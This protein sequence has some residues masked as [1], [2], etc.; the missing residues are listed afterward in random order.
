[1]IKKIDNVLSNNLIKNIIEYFKIVL[2]RQEWKSSLGWDQSLAPFSANILVHEITCNML[3]KQIKENVEKAIKVDF[4]KENL[5]FMP[6]IYIWNAGSYITWHPDDRYPY[7]GT[8][9]LNEEWDSNDGGL[10]LYKENETNEI[11]GIE[12]KY[13]TMVVNSA[14]ETNKHNYHCV[15]YIVPGSLKKR[16]TIQ[17]RTTPKEKKSFLYQ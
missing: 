1:M 7:S 13:N 16:I 17:W 3:I 10:F 9:Y 12:P 2:K 14:T 8:I 4:D 6:M 5:R 11:R 15:T